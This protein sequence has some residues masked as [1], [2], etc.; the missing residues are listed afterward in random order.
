VTD[1]L[2]SSDGDGPIPTSS[3]FA[4][5]P[6]GAGRLIGGAF[7]LLAKAERDLRA[8]SFF[9]G[10]V[11]LVTIGPIGA[12]LA[13]LVV[14]LDLTSLDPASI[15]AIGGR[16][17]QA[18]VWLSLATLLA[19]V[20]FIVVSVESPAIAIAMLAARLV[21]RPISVAGAVLLVRQRFWRVFWAGL[22]VNLLT[23]IGQQVMARLVPSSLDVGGLSGVIQIALAILIQTPFVYAIAGIVLGEVG[24]IESLRR[25]TILFR[26]RPLLALVVSLFGVAT[27]LVLLFGVDAGLGIVARVTQPFGIGQGGIGV[28]VGTLLAAALS[29]A[30]GT[31]VFTAAAVG[32]APQVLAF[33][34]LTHYVRGIESARHVVAGPRPWVPFI[35]RPMAVAIALGVLALFAGIVALGR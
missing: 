2:P 15:Q 18:A 1:P 17:D 34:G 11:T 30:F 12:L 27:E 28:F 32:A 19:L 22:L 3:P 6:L 4:A 5:I 29:F 20:G 13:V 16:A 8:A 24:V 14:R 35:S 21:G 33:T 7:D 23:V 10:F 31:L 26:A 9:Q 25:S